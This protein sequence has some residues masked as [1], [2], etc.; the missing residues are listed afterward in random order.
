MPTCAFSSIDIR[1]AVILT[2]IK[3]T[4]DASRIGVF[5]F[6]SDWFLYYVWQCDNW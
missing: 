2:I 1:V 6:G 5:N 3:L 4:N